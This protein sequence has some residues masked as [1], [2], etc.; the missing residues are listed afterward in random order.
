MHGVFKA[1][2]A[3]SSVLWIR[4]VFFDPDPDPTFQFVSDPT[5]IF[6][7]ILDMNFSYFTFVFLSCK[8][9]MTRYKPF[10]GVFFY[11]KELK[12]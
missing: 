11:K 8:C 3:L 9:V 6:K 4:N 12:F 1:F 2:S 7:N 10:V 5:R